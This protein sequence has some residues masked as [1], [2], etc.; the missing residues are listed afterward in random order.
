LRCLFLGAG[1][2]QGPSDARR[3][4]RLDWIAQR[5]LKNAAGEWCCGRGDCEVVE[6]VR[7]VAGGYYLPTFDELV[8]Y[9][10]ALRPPINIGKAVRCHRYD[11]SRRCFI[12]EQPGS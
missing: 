9:V 11:G 5:Q 10:E 8:P 3:H 12:I 7:A 4:R 6:D 1:S 2:W